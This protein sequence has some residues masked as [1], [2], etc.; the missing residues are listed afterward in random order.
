[1]NVAP[2]TPCHHAV[3]YC[4]DAGFLVPTLVSAQ[5]VARQVMPEGIADVIIMINGFT[6]GQAEAVLDQIQRLGLIGIAMP[7]VELPDT[8][9]F[10]KT[11]VPRS[12]LARFLIPEHLPAQY[13]HITYIDGDTQIVGDIRPLAVLEVPDGRI[14]AAGD[15]AWLGYHLH[16]RSLGPYL[17]GL[18][19]ESQ[20]DY[21]NS[22]VFSISRVTM[23]TLFP[24]AMAFFLAHSTLCRYHDQSALNAVFKGRRDVLSPRYNWIS[25]YAPLDMAGRFKPAILHFTGGGKPWQYAGAPWNGVFMPQYAALVDQWPVLKP[26][27]PPAWTEAQNQEARASNDRRL[28]LYRIAFPIKIARKWRFVRRM[29]AADFILS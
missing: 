1:M 16:D 7:A 19:L 22:G 23:E 6:P 8:V 14:A 26:F 17:H 15:K 25:D 13:T 27:A 3:V 2:P 28:R 4:T 9:S 5:Q 11:H 29:T 12:A 18:G 21:F 24:Q 10:N 20:D